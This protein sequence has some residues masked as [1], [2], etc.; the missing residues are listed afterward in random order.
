MLVVSW[1]CCS[2]LVTAA[3]SSNRV[4]DYDKDLESY[5]RGMPI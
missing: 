1:S 2:P 5:S 4:G 3:S